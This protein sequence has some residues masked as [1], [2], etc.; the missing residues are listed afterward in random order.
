MPK[1]PSAITIYEIA[2]EAGVSVATVSRA[3]RGHKGVSAEKKAVIDALV[4]KHNYH[5]NVMARGLKAKT[6]TI[7]IIAADIRNP[8]YATMVVACELAAN[9]RGYTVT[10][11]NVLSDSQVEYT[12]I[13]KLLAQRTD[14]IIQFGCRADAIV[15]DAGYVARINELSIP[16][17]TTGHLTGANCYRLPLDDVEGMRLVMEYLVARGHQRIAL[18]GGRNDVKSTYDKTQQYIYQ[19]GRYH[20]PYE[21]DYIKQNDYSVE[22]GYNCTRGLFTLRER[23]TAIIAINDYTAAGVYRALSEQGLN[24]PGDISVVSFDNTL[25][26]ILQPRLS[27]IDYDYPLYGSTIINTAIDAI[28]G[29]DPPKLIKM[30]PRL[31]IRD[32]I[33]DADA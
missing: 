10:V 11:C 13:D 3:L 17:I 21:T 22:S 8:Y 14:A 9:K 29:K 5:P 20:L 1:K 32:S 31:L 16:F 2:A 28:E 30:M 33:R 6:R 18:I 12:Y 26:E 24:V 27:S 4:V 15:P 19:L 7:G 25:A 23:P